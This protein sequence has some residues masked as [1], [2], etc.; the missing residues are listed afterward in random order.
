MFRAH[1]LIISRSKLHYTASGVITSIGD[2][3]S[4]RVHET[5]TYRC[6]D[7]RCC[8]MQFWPPDDKHMRSKH[9]QTWNKLIVKNNFCAS[10][11]LVTEIIILSCTVNN[12]SKI[13]NGVFILHSRMYR[14]SLL[15]YR[16]L[17][18]R[19]KQRKMNAKFWSEP[20]RDETVRVPWA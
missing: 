17:V 7:T 3:L 19:I 15:I 10:S 20:L 1:L 9:V 11:W 5:A 6:D 8:V 18:N 13:S 16:H 2:R 12:T 4:Q 14:T